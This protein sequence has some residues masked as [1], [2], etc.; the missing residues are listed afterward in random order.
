MNRSF[1]LSFNAYGV[2]KIDK[3]GKWIIET[4]EKDAQVTALTDHKYML[5]SS[6]P[7]FGDNLQQTHI[8]NFPEE[9]NT[10][11]IDKDAFGKSVFEFKMNNPSSG[12]N[13]MRWSGLLF[14]IVGTGWA[15]K[16]MIK[17]T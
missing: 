7:E 10:I 12:F 5:V 13:L 8:I 4:D 2:C 6:P 15:G 11:K 9:A 3:R 16:N 17:K 14:I 1:N